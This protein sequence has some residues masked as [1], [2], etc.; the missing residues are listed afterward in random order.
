M[1]NAANI[2][3]ASFDLYRA[4]IRDCYCAEHCVPMAYLI[5]L[6]SGRHAGGAEHIQLA[7]ALL[8]ALQDGTHARRT[9]TEYAA[10]LP[11]YEGKGWVACKL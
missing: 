5:S 1:T 11:A 4:E 6:D 7:T 10:S 8:G 9:Q 2:G 3:P